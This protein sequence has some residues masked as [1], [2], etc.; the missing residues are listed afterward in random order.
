MDF[1]DEE[2]GEDGD[3]IENEADKFALEYLISSDNWDT[4]IS[5]FKTTKE[6]VLLDAKRL[7]VHPSIIAGRIRKE[8]SNYTILGELLGS[9]Q[10]RE[11][12]MV[13]I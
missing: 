10:L 3:I 8:Q 6:S 11:M 9:G 5:R 7:D 4:C 2:D 13:N 12:L 1:F